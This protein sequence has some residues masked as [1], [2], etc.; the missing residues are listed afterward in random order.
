MP[1]DLL[2]LPGEVLA[3]IVRE[4]PFASKKSLVESCSRANNALPNLLKD[5][6]ICFV[7][8]KQYL[9]DDTGWIHYRKLYTVHLPKN[10]KRRGSTVFVREEKKR[11]KVRMSG[12]VEYVV[13]GPNSKWPT[14]R[15]N[16]TEYDAEEINA[17]NAYWMENS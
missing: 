1:G 3:L 6:A 15:A 9:S 17:H 4:L 2:Q 14:L 10:A 7:E 12:G 11:R 8:G 13:L 5:S 16:S